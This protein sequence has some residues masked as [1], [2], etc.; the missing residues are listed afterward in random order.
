[1]Y[2]NDADAENMKNYNYKID[3]TMI[4][5]GKAYAATT[6]IFAEGCGKV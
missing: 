1:M 2:L 5:T 3:V 6:C 4:L